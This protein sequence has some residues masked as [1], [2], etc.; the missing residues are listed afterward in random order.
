M[1]NEVRIPKENIKWNI[2]C[3]ET[4]N[5]C[6]EDILKTLFGMDWRIRDKVNVK[7]K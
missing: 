6:L 7:K 3:S 4:E 2:L 5:Q 1:T